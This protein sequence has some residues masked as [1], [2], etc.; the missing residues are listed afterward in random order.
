MDNISLVT[1]ALEYYD[2]NN[3]NYINTFNDAI[4]I[5]YVEAK[6]DMD[7][8]MIVFYDKNK[9]E[10]TRSRYEVIGR[11][12]TSS[13]IWIWAWAIPY[14]KKN[15]TN[16]IRK[17]WNYGAVLDPSIKYLKTELVTSRFRIADSIQLD[18]H[19]SIASYLSKNPLVYK[20]IEY[21][22]PTVDDEGYIQI[23]NMVQTEN[24]TI[25]YMF[26]LDYKEIEKTMEGIKNRK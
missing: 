3:Q 17:I 12:N 22:I 25:Y 10:L 4:Y 14:Y 19:A 13:N 6:T 8:N 15:N 7:H 21:D 5:K 11:Y 26:L 20:Y 1:T 18:I 23:K 24:Y 16:I 2:E 9:K